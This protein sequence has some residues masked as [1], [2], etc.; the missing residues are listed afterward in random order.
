MEVPREGGGYRGGK[1]V[2]RNSTEKRRTPEEER[3]CDKVKGVASSARLPEF[4]S[5]LC[6]K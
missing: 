4:N 3:Q 5:K 1:G 6:C 2:P